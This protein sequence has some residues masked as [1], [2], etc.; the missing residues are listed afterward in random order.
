MSRATNNQYV[1]DYV[2]PPG[3]TL[4]ETLEIRGISQAELAE[5]TGIAAKM[6]NE[7]IEGKARITSQIALE[8][9]RVLGVPAGFWNT[10]ES[11]YQEYLARKD[12][13]EKL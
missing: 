9:E 6:I 1:S 12:E 2:S 7:I 8:L 5:R 3:E 11:R 4:S 13:R 10:R